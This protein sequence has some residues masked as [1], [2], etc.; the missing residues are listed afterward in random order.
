MWILGNREWMYFALTGLLGCIVGSAQAIVGALGPRERAYALRAVIQCGVLTLSCIVLLTLSSGWYR[1]VIAASFLITLL[2][3]IERWNL[4][5]ARIRL[6]ESMSA[7][8]PNPI[9]V[10]DEASD[11]GLVPGDHGSEPERDCAGAI[12]SPALTDAGVCLVD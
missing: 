11:P 5:R 3:C 6:G 8:S 7:P 12:I 2:A 10:T 1:G 4:A 9:A